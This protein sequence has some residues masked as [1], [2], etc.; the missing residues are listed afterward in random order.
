MNIITKNKQIIYT[1][2][3]CI[4]VLEAIRMLKSIQFANFTS[5]A[6]VSKHGGFDHWLHD[7]TLADDIRK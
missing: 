2:D 1:G 7:L 5:I 4:D 3:D 6:L